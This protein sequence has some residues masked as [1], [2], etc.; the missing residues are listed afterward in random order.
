MR[1]RALSELAV[2]DF[3]ASGRSH[4]AHFT[5]REGREGVLQI[6][7]AVDLR[8][9]GLRSAGPSS[10]RRVCRRQALGSRRG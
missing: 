5:D 6:E 7:A 10:L 4:A 3:A 9:R 2:A 8:R 1:K